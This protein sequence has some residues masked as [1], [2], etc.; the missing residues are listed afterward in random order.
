M[1]QTEGYHVI[2]IGAGLSGAALA[3]MLAEQDRRVVVLE[4]TEAPGGTLKH[5]PGLA[6]LGTPYPAVPYSQARNIAGTLAL[7]RLSYE[8][9]HLLESA[10][11]SAG[12]P[13]RSVGSQR[14]AVTAEEARVFQ[15]SMAH[16][17]KNGYTVA[18]EENDPT[19]HALSNRGDAV[20]YTGV[21]NTLDDVQFDSEPLIQHLLDHENITVEPHT[22]AYAIKPRPGMGLTIWAHDRYLWADKVVVANGVHAVRLNQTFAQTL[23]F[24]HVHTLVLKEMPDLPTPLILNRGRVIIASDPDKRSGH[25]IAYG[26]EGTDLLQ[27]LTPVAEQVTPNAVVIDRFSS[28]VAESAEP[29]PWIGTQPGQPDL[30]ALIGL[31]TYGASWAFVAARRLADMILDD[32]SPRLQPLDQIV[33]S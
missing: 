5:V 10:L 7:W 24:V 29:V 6:L 13:L 22:E 26:P 9:L 16:L 30:Y 20:Q 28:R 23:N 12:L 4:A 17:K 2:V 8:N 14:L 25:L 33:E 1:P 3:R 31:G 27:I 15:Q 32:Q 11:E 19:L 21:M 18:F